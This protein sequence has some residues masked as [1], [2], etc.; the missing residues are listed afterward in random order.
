MQRYS[1]ADLHCDDD[2]RGTVDVVF[3][4]SLTPAML[5]VAPKV[6][7]IDPEISLA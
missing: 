4:G 2:D 3:M 7:T 6:R 1:G 5:R